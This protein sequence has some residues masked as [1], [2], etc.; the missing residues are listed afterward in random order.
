VCQPDVLGLC[1]RRRQRHHLQGQV[2]GGGP[3]AERPGSHG[4]LLFVGARPRRPGPGAYRGDHLGA[5][6]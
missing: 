2:L 5:G 4:R 3:S 1:R 6:L